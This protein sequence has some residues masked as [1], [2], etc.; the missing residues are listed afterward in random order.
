MLGLIN[1]Y[2][3]LKPFRF[4]VTFLFSSH[5]KDFY[6]R[7]SGQSDLTVTHAKNDKNP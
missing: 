7:T 2:F 3:V 5:P 1:V 6:C 4:V